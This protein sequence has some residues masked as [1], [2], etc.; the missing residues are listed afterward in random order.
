MKICAACGY[1]DKLGTKG[2]CPY[3]GEASWKDGATPKARARSAKAEE[4]AEAAPKKKS[5]KKRTKRES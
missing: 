4:T 2:T 5:S 3:C 1:G